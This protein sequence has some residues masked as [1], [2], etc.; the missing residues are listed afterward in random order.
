MKQVVQ[1][2]NQ[3]APELVEV[4]VPRVRPGHVLVASRASV[5]SAGTERML[6]SFGRAGWLEKVRSQPEKVRQVLTKMRTDGFAPTLRAVNAKLAQALPL[7]YS[8]AGVVLEVGEGV[9]HLRVGDRVVS[10]GPHAEVVCVPARLCARV[11]VDAADLPDEEAAFT[12]IAAIGL[13]GLRLAAP[14]LGETFAV[15]GLGLIGLLTVQLLRAHG[16]EVIGLDFDADRLAL[17]A[18]WGA[19]TVDLSVVADPVGAVAVATAGR[20]VDGALLTASTASSEPVHQA[21]QMCRKRG[22]IVLVGVTGLALQRADFYEKELTFQVSCSYGP[23]RY[24]PAYEQQGHDYPVGHVRWTEQRNFEAVLGLLADRRL[25]VRPLISERVPFGRAGDAYARLLEARQ[26]IG[27]VLTYEA[28][29]SGSVTRQERVIPAAGG[30]GRARLSDAPRVG[31]L[32]AGQFASQT[33][34]PAFRAAGACL[35]MVAS[36]TGLSG[37]LAGR[38]HGFARV[39][40][41]ERLVLE[42]PS[43]DVVVVATRHD[44]HA[45]LVAAALRAGKAVFV[46]KPLSID[47]AGLSEV[48]AALAEVQ[49][50]PLLG[51]GF[52]RRFAPHVAKA[53]GLLRGLPGPRTMVMTVNAGELPPDHWLVDP[54]VGG[55]RLVGEGCHFVDLLRFLADSPL[56]AVAAYPL[57]DGGRGGSF[58][59]QLAFQNGSTGTV[60]YLAHGHR[61]FPKER[62]EVFVGGRI[63]QLDNFRVLRGWGFPGF[64]RLGG[65]GQDK[66]HQA[67]VAAF[68]RAWRGDGAAPIPV[69]EVLEVARACLAARDGLGAPGDATRGMG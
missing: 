58:T 20:G 48:E 61:G 46:E 1:G 4:P 34:I 36:A 28:R 8:S 52:N 65:W 11:P 32:G 27:L 64:S 26:A 66:G 37:A 5:I 57:A 2:L 43:I 6:V 12:V 18:S 68:L 53:A 25:D 55:G 51:I 22:R 33:L 35:E 50:Q 9:T 67:G 40:S 10:N 47:A 3:K 39:A 24:D 19:T 31:F 62:L 56:E 17:A 44:S 30:P 59:L 7:G 41:D 45:R 42:D 21:A 38:Q 60:H 49:T 16:C 63:L 15:F 13:Q 69:A 29:Q 23:G 54:A 14:T